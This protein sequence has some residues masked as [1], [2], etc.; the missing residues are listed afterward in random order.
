MPARKRR[1]SSFL[2]GD[3]D[4]C[5][6]RHKTLTALSGLSHIPKIAKA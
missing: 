5:F 6:P 2:A 3:K 1:Y 4:V